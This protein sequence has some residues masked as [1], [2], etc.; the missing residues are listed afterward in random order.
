MLFPLVA[1]TSADAENAVA[2][3]PPASVSDP[4]SSRY[5]WQVWG[6]LVLALLLLLT[7][8]PDV[9][10]NPQFFAED[11]VW[12]SQAY[13]QGG[14]NVLFKPNAGYQHLLPRIV[15]A[16]VQPL[17]L[18]MAP[19]AFNIVGLLVRLLPVALLLSSRFDTLIPSRLARYFLAV[20]LVAIPNSSELYAILTNVNWHLALAHGMIF[21]ARPDSRPAWRT[22]DI[23]LAIIAGL[24]G[25]FSILLTV[26]GAIR[27]YLR[28]EPSILLLTV[29]T[30][31]CGVV[32]IIC[33]LFFTPEGSRVTGPLGASVPLFSHLIGG[34][35]MLTSLIGDTI[36]HNLIMDRYP[37]PWNWAF[38]A[39][40]LL[41]GAVLLAIAF[42]RGPLELRLF[43]VF[44][45][46]MCTASL[47]RPQGS[48]N[49]PQWKVLVEA[50][51]S[52]GARYWF[53]PTVVFIVALVSLTSKDAP[54]FARI[55]AF[56]LLALTPIG[57]L[58]DWRYFPWWETGFRASLPAYEAAPP[59][60]TVDIPA[61]PDKNWTLHL[62]KH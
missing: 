53:V 17:P 44:G 60:T 58:R 8:R 35:I 9:F 47:L 29:I 54:R 42:R 50:E 14:L 28:R 38:A 45:I 7:R 40:L 12:Y 6:F 3:G 20:Y 15:G 33:L 21:V 27:W 13:N 36:H 57:M 62:K 34:K 30:A 19:L 49:E 31:I 18:A 55:A 1:T 59:G 24:S 22:F 2:S 52:G 16:L 48:P 37:L 5:R 43:I 51:L 46:L 23:G 41:G 26:I 10:T 32:Q 25:P 56:T 11:G 4:A 39:F 61:L